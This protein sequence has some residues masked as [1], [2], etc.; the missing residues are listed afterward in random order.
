MG[1]HQRAAVVPFAGDD[2]GAALVVGD[3]R[4]RQRGAR[5]GAGAVIGHHLRRG[6]GEEQAGRH[7]L[8][9][10]I[11]ERQVAE[12][13]AP[14]R[15]L[16]QRRQ[17]GA[18]LLHDLLRA[19]HHRRSQRPHRRDEGVLLAQGEAAAEVVTAAR[20]AD[21]GVGKVERHRDVGH[22]RH[23]VVEF[24]Q[25]PVRPVQVI[26][27]DPHQFLPRVAGDIGQP[28]VDQGVAAPRL[29]ADAA[30][31]IARP[32]G[33]DLQVHLAADDLR[34][35]DAYLV[36]T[37]RPGI[38]GL[39]LLVELGGKEENA[40]RAAAP[41]DEEDRSIVHA[42]AVEID[43]QLGAVHV[44]D[45]VEPILVA[46]VGQRDRFVVDAAV[47]DV[48]QRLDRQQAGLARRAGYGSLAV[49][50]QQFRVG[51]GKG[52]GAAV[53]HQ[54]DIEQAVLKEVARCP[55]QQASK[56]VGARLARAQF[57][58]RGSDGD[59]QRTAV[60]GVVAQRELAVGHDGNRAVGVELQQIALR[61][62]HVEPL[63]RAG[64]GDPLPGGG[65]ERILGKYRRGKGA[66]QQDGDGDQ[67]P[68]VVF[69][70]SSFLLLD[71]VDA[72]AVR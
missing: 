41:F 4:R 1:Q 70:V 44:L 40:G 19:G 9:V 58:R 28:P 26:G 63:H 59:G 11:G 66:R 6:R 23:I 27:G 65:G 48:A 54:I 31:G 72:D 43:I 69:H 52:H 8:L 35:L 29:V 47:G 38:D 60:V 46:P 12:L 33:D 5:R 16:P 50:G 24:H 3:L 14:V 32:G 7:L 42:V 68:C 21:L 64:E 10:H 37:H 30:V 18:L 55:A 45:S 2:L 61:R 56:L 53:G 20:A 15:G 57:H 34:L 39:A 36:Q 62:L 51:R 25:H 22:G 17:E 67:Q 49:I 71:L 13:V